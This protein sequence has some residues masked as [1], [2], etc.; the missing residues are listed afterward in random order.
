MKIENNLSS[1]GKIS[2]AVS[3]DSIHELLSATK[4]HILVQK[5]TPDSTL[6][7]YVNYSRIK[8]M[9]KICNVKC[10][11]EMDFVRL[12][13]LSS[14]VSKKKKT[15]NWLDYIELKYYSIVSMFILLC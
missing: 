7:T 12:K 11:V 1:R 5:V 4:H 9:T 13:K 3:D 15:Q 6:Y 2:G 14:L 10:N 8:S